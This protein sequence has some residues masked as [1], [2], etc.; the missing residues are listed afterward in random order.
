[1]PHAVYGAM[2][3][4]ESLSVLAP[5]IHGH[6]MGLQKYANVQEATGR[7]ETREVYKEVLP[8]AQENVEGLGF[9]GEWQALLSGLPEDRGR[10]ASSPSFF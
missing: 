10:G 9:E 7:P 8:V 5:V 6:H 1:M 3:A 2:L 4:R